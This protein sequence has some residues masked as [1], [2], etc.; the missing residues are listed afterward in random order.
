MVAQLV[1]DLK[2][3]AGRLAAPARRSTPGVHA[4]QDELLGVRI[5]LEHAE[6]GDHGRRAGAAEAEPLRDR[7]PPGPSPCPTVVQKSSRSTNVR[8][9]VRRDHDHLAAA[10]RDL[11]CAA[12]PRQPRPRVLVVADHGRVQV[13]VAVDLRGA[14]E[15]DVDPPGPIQ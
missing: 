2:L 15:R 9:A 5:W 4:R 8:G 10:R 6:I 11:G 13:R 14:E 1:G 12:G 3:P 7:G